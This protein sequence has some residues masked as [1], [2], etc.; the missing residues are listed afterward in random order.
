MFLEKPSMFQVNTVK[1]C[2]DSVRPTGDLVPVGSIEKDEDHT[3]VTGGLE[4]E[5]RTEGYPGIE[6][7]EAAIFFAFDYELF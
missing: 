5:D 2:L 3:E 6:E 7:W 4:E 1:D